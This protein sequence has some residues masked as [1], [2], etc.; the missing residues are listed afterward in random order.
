MKK[1]MSNQE[2]NLM[3]HWKDVRRN[4]V[5][6]L[7]F[8]GPIQT[9]QWIFMNLSSLHSDWIH[10]HTSI[11]TLLRGESTDRQTSFIHPVETHSA[12]PVAFQFAKFA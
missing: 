10:P 6:I 12:A 7:N 4:I 3:S 8:I 11:V 1:W 5:S 9:V 2:Q